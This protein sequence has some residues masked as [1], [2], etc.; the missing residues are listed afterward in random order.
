MINFARFGSKVALMSAAVLLAGFAAGA[1]SSADRPP[2]EKVDSVPAAPADQGSQNLVAQLSRAF[3]QAAAKVSPS[4]VPI[5]A[6]S[7]V[8]V[9]GM[10]GL[11]DDALRQFFGDDFFKRF[12]G[13]APEQKQIKRSLGSGVIVSK[14]GYI[15]TNNHVV[16]GAQKLTVMLDEK[17]SYPAKVVGTDPQSDVAVVQIDASGLPAATLGTSADV[18]VGEWVIAVGNPFALLHTV[19][20]GIISA[21]GRSSVENTA[22]QDFLQTDAAINPGNSGG[23]LADL[24]GN[25]IGINTAIATPSGGNV[26]LGFAIPIDLAK[27]VMDQLIAK[28][29][30]SRGYLGLTPQDIDQDLD[31][32]LKLGTTTGVLISEVVPGSPA[33]KAGIKAGDMIV[34]FNGAKIQD[35]NQFRGLV[36]QAAPGSTVTVTVLHDGHQTDLRV[37][38]AERPAEPGGQAAPPQE[39]PESRPS[40][41]LGLTVQTLTPDIA[42][43][44]GYK[45]NETGVVISQV[46]PG[47]AADEAGLEAGDVIKEVDRRRVPTAEEFEREMRSFKSGDVVA[48]LVM[49]GGVTV[50]VAVKVP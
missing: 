16:S 43:Q 23:A 9:P 5:Y 42:Q 6:E 40:S 11:P 3:E 41:R 29:K 17:K 35:S 50:F 1:C 30:V 39:S 46:A 26:G 38:L 34:A 4:V 13:Q 12:F 32:A 49:R 33:D 45:R 31:K 10:T 2:A 14:D 25:V 18:K 20:H 15:L 44:L 28:G 37:T 24:E 36:A 19:T 8:K 22:Y 7:V 21:K 27:G 48:L 47:G